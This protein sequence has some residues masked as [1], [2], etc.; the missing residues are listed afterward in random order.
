MEIL[1]DK[2]MFGSF[3]DVRTHMKVEHLESIRILSVRYWGI[4]VPSRG[5]YTLP[6]IEQIING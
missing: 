1:T 4:N 5:V 3:K 2:G 6:M